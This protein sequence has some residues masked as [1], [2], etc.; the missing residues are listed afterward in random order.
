MTEIQFATNEL[1]AV[2]AQC[3]ADIARESESV[4]QPS[5]HVSTMPAASNQAEK[6]SINAGQAPHEPENE[7]EGATETLSVQTGEDSSRQ[8]ISE[9]CATAQSSAQQTSS[10][11]APTQDATASFGKTI[12]EKADAC[13]N[14]IEQRGSD[15][16]WVNRF[17]T[18]DHDLL[19]PSEP[20][21]CACP[22]LLTGLTI[23]GTTIL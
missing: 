5:E 16:D 1:I 19:W 13:E 10:T 7:P 8:T 11:G 2:A 6:E 18:E 3:L 21:S 22:T 17:M 14:A 15:K 23:S 20:V 4:N 9:Q 12:P